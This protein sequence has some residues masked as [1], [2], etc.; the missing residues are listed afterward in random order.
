MLSDRARRIG[1]ADMRRCAAAVA[2]ALS[3]ACGSPTM[4]APMPGATGQERVNLSG[5]ITDEDGTPVAGALVALGSD[6][7]AV[8]QYTSSTDA[9]GRYQFDF[10]LVLPEPRFIRASTSAA[11]NIQALLWPAGSYTSVK[12][13]RL[14]RLLTIA[15]GGSTVISI[16][17][18]SSLCVWEFGNSSDHVCAWFLLRYIGPVRVT[19]EARP[20]D[21]GPAPLVGWDNRGETNH[22]STLTGSQTALLGINL[23]IPIV[24]G[25]YRYEVVTSAESP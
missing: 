19:V 11:S 22:F 1:E 12:N 13:V 4:P 24:G 17:Q 8:R 3:V 16:D 21:G 14:R 7:N 9:N 20:L 18:D 15:A 10:P 25:P 5:V 23:T 6:L 2:I